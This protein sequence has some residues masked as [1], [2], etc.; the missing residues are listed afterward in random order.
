MDFVDNQIDQSTGTIV[1]RAILDNPG[2]FI[3]P[4]FFGRIRLLVERDAEKILI[5]DV[6]IGTDRSRRFVFI[7]NDEGKVDRKFVTLGKLYSKELRVI[8]KGLTRD[9]RIIL[10]N[11]MRVRAGAPV[12]AE[13]VDLS[14]QY[15]L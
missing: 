3:L 8:E 11:L 10:N 15:P 2:G 4:G 13:E 7:V 9:D 12:E 6:V 1:G 5:P 14:S